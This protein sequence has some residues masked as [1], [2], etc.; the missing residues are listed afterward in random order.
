MLADVLCV[1]C[2][3]TIPDSNA[4]Y[5]AENKHWICRMCFINITTDEIMG[6]GVAKMLGS[7][8]RPSML[9]AAAKTFD[10]L[11]KKQEKEQPHQP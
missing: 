3:T 10:S 4:L 2:K 11:K 7:H 8:I 1:S 6:K 5:D 9:S